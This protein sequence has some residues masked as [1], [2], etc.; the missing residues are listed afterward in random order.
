M[1]SAVH[2]APTAKDI[3]IAGLGGRKM[4]FEGLDGPLRPQEGSFPKLADGMSSITYRHGAAASPCPPAGP[5][6]AG[7]GGEDVL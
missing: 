4:R 6:V 1:G 3:L 7:A 5:A 2:T